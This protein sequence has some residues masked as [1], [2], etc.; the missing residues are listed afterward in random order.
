MRKTLFAAVVCS[1]FVG[2]TGA[3]AEGTDH[4][5]V[6]GSSTPSPSPPLLPTTLQAK[7]PAPQVSLPPAW[8]PIAAIPGGVVAKAAPAPSRIPV[9][10]IASLSSSGDNLNG[11]HLRVAVKPVKVAALA[12]EVNR[13]A[14]SSSV[15]SDESK[16]KVVEAKVDQLK[17]R[18]R[19]SI[20]AK[21]AS[22]PPTMDQK[23]DLR[24]AEAQKPAAKPVVKKQVKADSRPTV[25][26]RPAD[27]SQRAEENYQ[28]GLIAYDRGDGLRAQ[29]LLALSMQQGHARAGNDLAL[30][31][32][33]RGDTAA[34]LDCLEN[35]ERSGHLTV[36]GFGLLVRLTKSNQG[37]KAAL[38]V[39]ARNPRFSGELSYALYNGA[40]LLSLSDG[41]NALTVYKEAIEKFGGTTATLSGAVIASMLNQNV[42]QAK[43]Y[44]NQLNH[45]DASDALKTLLAKKI[46]AMQTIES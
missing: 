2:A 13:S 35:V 18:E 17:E 39:L 4:T 6:V 5:P 46:D 24:D 14:T 15:L 28:A 27:L 1:T 10:A 26:S 22:V 34:S 12:N 38:D 29:E 25:V 19:A 33:L 44:L 32:S 21:E 31:Y 7:S 45:T 36:D 23:A 42:D 43:T 41:T 8:A 37:D 3:S 11:D 9:S 40:L 16:N 30:L 20:A